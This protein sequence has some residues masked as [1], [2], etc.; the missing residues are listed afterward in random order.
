MRHLSKFLGSLVEMF[1]QAEATNG[2]LELPADLVRLF[3]PAMREAVA[4]AEA[5]ERRAE[6]ADEL[7]AV[8]RDLDVIAYAKAGAPRPCAE[9]VD[10]S[11]AMRREQAGI[12]A[13]QATASGDDMGAAC[14]GALARGENIVL[15]PVVARPFGDG[16]SAA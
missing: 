6:Q 15:F 8:A 13:E 4:S 5:L 14:L 10:L 1:E 16:G 3:T 9:V 11:E 7:E 12:C 2:P